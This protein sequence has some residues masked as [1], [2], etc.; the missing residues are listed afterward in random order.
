MTISTEFLV[1][2]LVV[3]LVPG[4]GVIYTVSHGLFGGRRPSALAAVGCTLGIVPHLVAA[5]LGLS[6]L[7]HTSARVFQVMKLAGV[8]Y[9]LYLAWG[10]W[11]STGSLAI[12][13]PTG[14][15]SDRAIVV[16]GTVV[17]LLNP[18]L[19][20]FFFAFLPQFVDAGSP[21]TAALA[22]LGAVFMVVT[23]VVFLAYGLV[24]STVRERVV[25]SPTVVRR[26]QRGLAVAFAGL[27]LRLAFEDR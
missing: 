21:S 23:L 12:Q 3:A 18:K 19:T 15:R 13:K 14:A 24:A 22:L 20:I 2:A 7:V 6:A 11:R 25:G 5:T 17:N 4:T 26:L 27:G 8:A 1:T 9:L 16:R 10:M